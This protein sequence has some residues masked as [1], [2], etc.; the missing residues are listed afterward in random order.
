MGIQRGVAIGVPDLDHVAIAVLAPGPGHHPRRH[1]HHV[2]AGRR[3]EV[4]ALVHAQ[5][6]AHR[7]DPAPERRGDVALAHRLAG[8]VGRLAD[9]LVGEQLLQHLELL[10]AGIQALR[11]LA[12]AADLGAL[13]LQRG[14]DF[15]A[16][17]RSRR[18]EQPGAHEAP[19]QQA[20]TD[21]ASPGQHQQPRL[22]MD[23]AS[24]P[25]V[26]AQKNDVHDLSFI[27]AG[28]SETLSA[29]IPTQ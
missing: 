5:A 13:R 24:G 29:T 16:G 12:G 21:H 11:V 6:A 23:G 22:Q 2:A 20:G 7:I 17:H 1:G 15:D 10:L 25:M 18:A 26:P 27:R 14:I 28:S 8:Q 4:D 9:V 19:G 3:G